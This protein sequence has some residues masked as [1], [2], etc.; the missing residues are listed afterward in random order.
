MAH[1][2]TAG[3][4]HFEGRCLRDDRL[5]HQIPIQGPAALAVSEAL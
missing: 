1:W 2:L 5:Q 3:K 4:G